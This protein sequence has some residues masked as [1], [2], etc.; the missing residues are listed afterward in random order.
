MPQMAPIMWMQL[1]IMF[2]SLFML[3]YI[4][5]FFMSSYNPK[6]IFNKLMINKKNW[7]W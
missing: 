3:T 4:I 1:F 6:L 2:S 5:M 7:K